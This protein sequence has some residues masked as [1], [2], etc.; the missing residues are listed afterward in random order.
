MEKV[1]FISGGVFIYWSSILLT[2]AV[3]T[4]MML[5]IAVYLGKSK[6]AMGAFAAVPVAALLSMVLGRLIHWYC[7]ADA[8]ES[9]EA[10][11]SNFSA[12][13]YALVGAF[14][15]CILTACT[16]R[17]VRIVKN[18]PQ[19]LDAMAI[20][21]GA[22][23][24]V[25][26][27]ASLF[28]SSNRGIVVPD[29][30]GL[31]VA[32]PVTNAVSGVVENRLATFM[33]QAVFTGA[34]VLI[35][36]VYMFWRWARKKPVPDGDIDLLFLSAYCGSQVLL[37]STR[38]D[39]LFL[40]SNGFISVVQIL[41]AIVLVLVLVL[42]SIRMVSRRGLKFYH[43]ALWIGFAA[44]LGVACYME[45]Y[46]Q[47]H[48]DQAAFAYSVMAAAIAAMLLLAVIVRALGF[49]KPAA[50]QPREKKPRKAKAPAVIPEAPIQEETVPAIPAVDTPAPEI[51]AAE[52]ETPPVKKGEEDWEDQWV[53]VSETAAEDDS[54][55]RD[56][57]F[58]EKD[59][60]IEEDHEEKVLSVRQAQPVSDFDEDWEDD[61][62]EP[63][64]EPEE[65][66]DLRLEDL[67][68]FKK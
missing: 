29:H 55:L 43:V 61:W 9:L 3:V 19:M 65:D 42:F 49:L 60:A 21:G 44:A 7:R 48:G 33:L 66:W 35:L 16:L 52:S 15:G 59:W 31:P 8:Y 68:F 1:A 51:S 11:M 4:A 56:L 26:R 13:G 57:A 36:L 20:A 17:L 22:G 5:F 2:L 24:A 67:E 27:L 39:S 46:V 30:L 6:N 58:L 53:D 25:G 10:A 38:Y 40:R 62:S 34:L 50:K 28:N 14:A 37:D 32:Y 18:L 12:G 63:V 45:Y 47:R 64:K 23:I 54:W 41:S